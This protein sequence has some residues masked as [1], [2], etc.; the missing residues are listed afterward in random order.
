MAQHTKMLMAKLIIH[1]QACVFYMPMFTPPV[2][3]T[4]VAAEKVPLHLPLLLL[5]KLCTRH[6]WPTLTQAEL[7]ICFAG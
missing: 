3:D 1:K 2:K 4:M 7:E 6:C 5:E